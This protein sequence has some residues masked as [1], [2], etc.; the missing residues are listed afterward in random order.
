MGG[1]GM[2]RAHH[3]HGMGAARAWTSARIVIVIIIVIID[4]KY[5]EDERNAGSACPM[6]SFY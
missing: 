1:R 5:V 2:A 3:C 4:A 6:F